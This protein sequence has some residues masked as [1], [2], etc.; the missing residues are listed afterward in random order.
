MDLE[1]IQ[2]QIKNIEEK[3]KI[4]PPNQ[5]LELINELLELAS[6]LEAS[7]LKTEIIEDN[8]EQI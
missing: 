4:T 2:E 1:Q 7:L 3:I 5:Q 6:G 8:D